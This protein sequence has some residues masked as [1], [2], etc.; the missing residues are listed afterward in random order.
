MSNVEKCARCGRSSANVWSVNELFC[1]RCAE[2][3]GTCYM[4]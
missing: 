3:F 2:M 1:E 4:C